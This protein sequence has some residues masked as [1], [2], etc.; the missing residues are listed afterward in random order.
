VTEVGKA[1]YFSMAEAL[2]IIATAA[3]LGVVI[4]MNVYALNQRLHYSPNKISITST[5]SSL[6]SDS[7]LSVLST[8]NFQQ[9]L[10]Q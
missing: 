2:G 8:V 10:R 9:G 5:A 4:S 6:F 7:S 1:E 3:I